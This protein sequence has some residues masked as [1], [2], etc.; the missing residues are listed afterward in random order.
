MSEA[1][2]A[3]GLSKSTPAELIADVQRLR[4]ASLEAYYA[5][6]IE[7]SRETFGP[8]LRTKG[9]I[10]H[11]RKELTEIEREPH[12][13]SEWIDVVI[14]AMDG[15]WRHGGKA[16]DLMPALLAEQQKNMA[17]VW[18]DWRT[19]SEDSAIEHDRSRDATGTTGGD[20]G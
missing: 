13:L 6:Q 8:A 18:P 11:I 4:T 9:V 14:L 5:R 10:D 3:Q 1:L 7:W 2:I 15:F 19:M 16:E 12:D 20:H 17:R